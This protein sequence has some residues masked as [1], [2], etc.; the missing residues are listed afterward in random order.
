M[1]IFGGNQGPIPLSQLDTNFAECATDADLAAHTASATGV[2]GVGAGDVVGTVKVQTLTNKTVNLANNTLTG[3][4]AQF[5]TAVSDDNFAYVG[6]TN[7]FSQNQV[8]SVTDNT[9]PALKITQAGTGHALLVEDVASDT[10]PFVIDQN[11]LTG[12]GTATPQSQLDVRT[13]TGASI[14]AGR[15]TNVA[16]T[17]EPGYFDI[18]AP[19][20]SGIEN[21]WMRIKSVV[22][23]ATNAT[24][25]ADTVFMSMRAGTLTEDMR[26]SGG[27]LG[28]GVTPSAW[29]SSERAIDIGNTG[30]IGR[31]S[32]AA[33]VLNFN[34]YLNSSAQYIYKISSYASSYQQLAGQHKW[35][36]APSGTAG[37]AITFTQA[38]TLDASGNLGL[39]LAGAS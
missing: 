2:H 33:L 32:D 24:E 37:N 21:F 13:G 14:I 35:F 16:A 31:Q 20:A 30:A 36:T 9:N 3:T 26:L 1:N 10:T 8:I 22:T 15:S 34:S 11:G 7:T 39:G 23:D 25:D 17:S 27:N 12:V 4:K 38:M 19:N 28:L 5:D 6:T 18:K 29:G